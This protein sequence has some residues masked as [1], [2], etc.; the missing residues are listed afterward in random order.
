MSGGARCFNLSIEFIE[1]EV[2]SLGQSLDPEWA[3]RTNPSL[4]DY[5]GK[6]EKHRPD[7]ESDPVP[8]PHQSR[9]LTHLLARRGDVANNP[10]GGHGA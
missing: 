2:G 5:G 1:G 6:G 7:D 4:L 10:G 9:L 8:D 3:I